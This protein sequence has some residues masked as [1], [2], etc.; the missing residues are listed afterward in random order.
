MKK[1]ILLTIAVT[2]SALSFAQKNEIKVIEKAIKNL[3]FADAK[4]A[5][6]SA[7]ALIGNMDDKTKAKFYFLK[8]QSLYAKGKG[9]DKDMDNAITAMEN[10]VNLESSTGKPKYTSKINE[11]KTGMINNYIAKSNDAFKS[12]DFKTAANGFEKAY[13]MSP[14]DTVYLYYAAS[15]AV[16]HQDFSTALNLYQQLKNIN[17]TGI[18][19]NYYATKTETNVEEY[20]SNKTTRDFSVKSKTHSKPRDEKTKSRKAEI[21]KN[22]AL[23]YVTQGENDKALTAMAEAR[24]E[25][26]DDLGLL[27][28]EA[29]VYLKMGNKEK[30]KSLMH[31]ATLKDPN[32]AELQYNLGV[33]AAEGG[34]AEEAK[35]YYKKAITLDPNYI[36]AY[37]NLA[38]V[39]LG[40]ETAI[41][42]EMNTLGNSSA[43][44]KRYDVLK[45]KRSQLYA[46][47][48]PYLE[49]ALELRGNDINASKTLMNIYGAQG[50]TAKFKAM[51]TRV[52]QMEANS[53]SGN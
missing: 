2:F 51:K 15:S 11:L 23:I 20:F 30:F 16:S 39:I 7:E 24:T 31:E 43:D 32:N 22:I 6:S 49:K 18:E 25:N 9:S 10:L 3:K 52:E 33:L 45:E 1:L 42:E 13:K 48:I 27:L 46:Q 40:D 36:D 12:K 37:N 47:A 26:P 53:T 35:T 8:V 38:V 29:N 28:S 41:I 21:V 34:S 44:N 17:Y 50:E 19:T 4:S 14:K 5:L